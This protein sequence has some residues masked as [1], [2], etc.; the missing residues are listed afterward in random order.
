MQCM[1]ACVHAVYASTS[2]IA[3]AAKLTK[4]LLVENE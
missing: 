4:R 3:T 2:G 1:H